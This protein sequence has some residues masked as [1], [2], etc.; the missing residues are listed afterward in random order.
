MRAHTCHS[1]V[2]LKLDFQVRRWN[3]KVIWFYIV[4]ALKPVAACGAGLICWPGSSM[5]DNSL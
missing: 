3:Y 5:S 4:I 1:E 2:P